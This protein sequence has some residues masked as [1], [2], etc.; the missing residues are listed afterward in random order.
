MKYLY[1]TFRDAA[2]I[3]DKDGIIK[4]YESTY[5]PVPKN[6]KSEIFKEE[7]NRMKERPV[8]TSQLCNMMHC[9]FGYLP[10]PKY[11]NIGRYC[12]DEIC[13]L[14]DNAYIRYE[15]QETVYRGEKLTTHKADY[16]SDQQLM[17]NKDDKPASI[18]LTWSHMKD[19]L[20]GYEWLY[21]E[22]IA[23][24]NKLSGCDVRKKFTVREYIEEFK[25]YKDIPEVIEF[26]NKYVYNKEYVKKNTGLGRKM[27][28]YPLDPNPKRSATIAKMILINGGLMKN[29]SCSTTMPFLITSGVAEKINYSGNIIVPVD[30]ELIDILKKYGKL[31]TILDGGYVKLK[32]KNSLP[33]GY[34]YDYMRFSDYKLDVTF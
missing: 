20:L 33:P 11:K 1:I 28:F 18:W 19:E 15:N 5:G 26:L 2:L 12:V 27:N 21:E 31:P 32:I 34:E 3:I 10:S 24:F 4:R 7:V 16:N 8:D 29:A 6:E 14:V 22:I 30:E 13:S 23:M 25:K 17:K 9:M